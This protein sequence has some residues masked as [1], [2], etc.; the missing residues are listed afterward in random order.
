SWALLGVDEQVLARRLA[1]FSGGASIA[2]I[3][4]VCGGSEETLADLVDKSLVE[5]DGERYRMLESIRLFC[6]ERLAESGEQEELRRSHARYLLGFARAADPHLL[7]AEQL[8][9]L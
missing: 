6:L 1:V 4:A 8:E 9:W 7:G 3:E 2:A 5:R